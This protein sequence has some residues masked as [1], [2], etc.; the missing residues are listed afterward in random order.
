[1][2]CKTLSLQLKFIIFCNKLYY[3]NNS[4]CKSHIHFYYNTNNKDYIIF[5]NN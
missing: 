3:I 1:M 2:I 4:Y 5:N